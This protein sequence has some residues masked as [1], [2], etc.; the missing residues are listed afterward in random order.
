V[1]PAAALGYRGDM[2]PISRR[3]HAV[4]DYVT[5]ATELVLPHVL[6]ASS[7]ARR[8]LRFSG[9]NAGV[10]G[11]L[12]KHELGLVELVPMRV[13]LALDALFATTFLGA[14]ALMRDERPAVRGTLAALGVTGA[15]AA[16]LTNPDK[17]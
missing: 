15:L 11:A 2:R 12:T 14:A 8:L 1:F 5:A 7:S 9:A 10:L 4:V 16:A 6:P 3:Q 17:T 13:H